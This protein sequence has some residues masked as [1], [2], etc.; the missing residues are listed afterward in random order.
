MLL[1]QSGALLS[2]HRIHA[3]HASDAWAD[4]SDS[5]LVDNAILNCPEICN[6]TEKNPICAPIPGIAS[7]F[8][9]AF[10]AI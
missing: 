4:L 3:L 5:T 10:G 7:N 6:A 9:L 2:P 1:L 8:E